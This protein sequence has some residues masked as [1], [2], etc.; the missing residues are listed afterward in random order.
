[1][2]VLLLLSYGCLIIVN[3]LGLFI[4][5]P[6]VGLPCVIAVFPDQ[7]HLFFGVSVI[8]EQSQKIMAMIIK[9]INVTIVELI[10]VDRHPC[11]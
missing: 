6:L 7:T 2:L 9:P 8:D 1:M 10:L 5:V 4:T 3:V 11:A